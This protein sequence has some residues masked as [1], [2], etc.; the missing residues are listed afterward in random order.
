MKFARAGMRRFELPLVTPLATAHGRI[1]SRAGHLVTLMDDAG[2]IG[3]GEATPLAEFGTEDLETSRRAIEGA[4]H[5]LVGQEAASLD[6]ALRVCA[7]LCASSPC[8]H[9]AID[10]ALHDLAAKR[11]DRSLAK[12]LRASAEL[13]GEP[14]TRIRVQALVSGASP[15]AVAVAADHRLADGFETFKLKLAVSPDERDPARDVDRVAALRDAVGPARRLR[16]D[17]NE[18]WTVREAERALRSF[19][20]FDIEFVEQPVAREDREG[21]R[22]LD[23]SGAIPVAADEALLG[24]GCDACFELGAARI[25]VLKPAALGGIA[26][27]LPILRRAA[28]QGIRVVLSSLIEGAVGRSAV[29][30]LAAGVAD[31][32]E[33]HGLGTQSLLAADLALG[34]EVR[35]GGIDVAAASGLGVDLA[36]A[37]EERP[38]AGRGPR[39]SRVAWGEAQTIEAPLRSR[40]PRG[41][42]ASEADRAPYE[43]ARGW[44]SRLAMHDPASEALLDDSSSNASA[45]IDYARLVSIATSMAQRLDELGLVEGDLVA[46]LAG[47]SV[48]GVGLIHAMLDRGLVLLPLNARLTEREHEALLRRS[49]ARLLISARC[50]DDR[51]ADAGL[52]AGARRLAA[53]A[54]CG[55]ALLDEKE[56]DLAMADDV[57]LDARVTGVGQRQREAFVTDEAALV[58]YTSGTSGRSKGAVLALD[59]LIASAEASTE[60]LGFEAHDR[61]LLCMPLFHIGGLSI[62]IRSALLGTSVVLH[63]RFDAERVAR[64]IDTQ[65]VTRVSLVATMLEKL[66]ATRGERPAPASLSLVLL[67]GGPASQDLL[68]RAAAAGYPVAPTYGL[69]EA[70]SQVATRPPFV[71]SPDASDLAAGLQPLPG[72]EVCIVDAK[73]R[74]LEAGEEGEIRVRGRIV[75]R[76]YL[77]E[78]ESRPGD[79]SSGD[80]EAS[81]D[82][83]ED[84]WLSTGDLGRLDAKGH[85][86][87]IDRRAD[88]I[89]SGGENVYPAEIESVLVAHPDIEE[90]GVVGRAD[91]EFGARP[92]A[93]V[94]LRSGASMGR[95]DFDAFCRE[96]LAGYKVPDSFFEVASLPRT[97]TGKLLRRELSMSAAAG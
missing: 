58:L 86:R 80:T 44:I 40:S 92:V 31:P 32:K 66:I 96:R 22:F 9:S 91:A 15:D 61:W 37:W 48:A 46:V 11:A 71:A 95:S 47:P 16:L 23:A 63:E 33:T 19:E 7:E 54:G 88:L 24:P 89:V 38:V 79:P 78:A 30:A 69:T 3:F 84:G 62:L 18:A 67:G 56:P 8:A 34:N 12:W 87:V 59:S 28:E 45:S 35:D 17:A 76:G 5:A 2:R 51:G 52:D 42:R 21:L 70:A 68:A 25:F 90:A 60:L 6:Q 49:N 64:A 53:S 13:P 73:G 93:F 94:V 20:R 29:L 43:T 74:P 14:A 1:A 26:R 65:D 85:L 55:L 77:G 4:L 81:S 27:S 57:E 82:A 36:A 72:V 97:A 50:E 75:M 10:S 41:H 39:A 83:I